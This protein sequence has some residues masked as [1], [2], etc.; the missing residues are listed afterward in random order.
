MA[1]TISKWKATAKAELWHY[2]AM[3]PIVM[4]LTI[5]EWK[6]TANA[7]RA[8]T[9]RRGHVGVSLADRLRPSSQRCSSAN[10][11]CKHP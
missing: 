2:I 11:A 8:L 10:T 5:S 4:A 6:A 1:L 9:S 3:A 7:E